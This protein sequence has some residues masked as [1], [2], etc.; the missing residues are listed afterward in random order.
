MMNRN[1]WGKPGSGISQAFANQIHINV[2]EV[3]DCNVSEENDEAEILG[4]NF[5]NLIHIDT[6]SFN[7]VVDYF[8]EILEIAK[9]QSESISQLINDEK[10][11]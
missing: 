5:D 4:L 2:K 1:M 10:K 11:K 6:N 9:E 8:K 7:K 3:S